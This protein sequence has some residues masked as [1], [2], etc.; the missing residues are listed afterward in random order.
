MEKGSGEVQEVRSA[1][2]MRVTTT[3]IENKG[4]VSSNG[5]VETCTRVSTRRTKET[6]TAKC[7]GLMAVATRESGFAVS[8]MDTAR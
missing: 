5:Q 1:T 3:Q 7:I 8:N 2:A 4:T 6:V